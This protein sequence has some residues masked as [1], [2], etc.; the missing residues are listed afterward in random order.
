MAFVFAIIIV[1]EACLRFIYFGMDAFSPAKINS[2]SLIIN[3]D[4]AKPAANTDIYYELKPNLDNL[5]RGKR[6]TTNS[7][8]LADKEYP[9]NKPDQTFRIAVIG[10]SWTMATGVEAENT[11]HAL[12][13]NMLQSQPKKNLAGRNIEIINFGVEYYGLGEMI[14]TTKHKALPYKPDMIIFA[15]TTS[16]PAILW[17][18]D[19]PPFKRTNT[20][21]PFWQSYL[22]QSVMGLFGK[23][24]YKKRK[25][26]MV[27]KG[28]GAYSRQIQRS[29]NELAKL[30]K[31]N[32]IEVALL[33]LTSKE[34]YLDEASMQFAGKLA[35]NYGFTFMPISL[36]TEAG[37]HNIKDKVITNLDT[38][39][40]ETGHKLIADRIYKELWE[41]EK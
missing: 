16:T 4:Y 23:E 39:P 9:L 19:R 2:Y 29:I 34:Y 17:E 30:T 38:H 10:S 36:E 40:N 18:D 35:N 14:A 8:G 20:T 6:L 1:L 37:I 13:E 25:R 22:L 7:H 3:S 41:G 21:P 24:A 5:F 27:K 11:Y 28:R 15:I 31:D 26:P 32:D 33:W 12:L